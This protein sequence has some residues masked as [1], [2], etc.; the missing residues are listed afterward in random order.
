MNSGDPQVPVTNVFITIDTEVST[1]L[2]ENWRTTA[3]SEEIERDIYGR[4]DTGEL[5]I[6][7]Q[8]DVM[9]SYG[10]KATFFVEALFACEVGIQPLQRVLDA[11]RQY[12]HDAQLHIHTEWLPRLSKPLLDSKY[13]QHIRNFSVEDQAKLIGRGKSIFQACGMEVKA[14]RAGNYGA[15]F[16]TLRALRENGIYF[17]TSYNFVRLEAAC[18]MSMPEPLLQPQNFEGV[19]ELPVS[20][21]RDGLRHYRPLQI[22][23]CS[24][25]EIENT[26]LSAWQMGWYSV[27]I[28]SHSF[29]LLN[30]PAQAGERPTASRIRDRRFERICRFLAQQKEKFRTLTFSELMPEEISTISP[31][32]IPTSGLHHTAWR[33]LEQLADRVS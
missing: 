12:G 30:R 8:M 31:G 24:Q 16:D 33:Y 20:F 27:V 7:H 17:D 10:I 6:V 18:G 26:L 13:G 5:G 2:S 32:R 21:F 4:T 9:N 28:V 14:F 22:C 11:I 19:F 15:N 25:T 1:P 29:E 23:A 3:L